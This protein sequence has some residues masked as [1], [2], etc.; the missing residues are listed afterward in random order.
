MY[1]GK[2]TLLENGMVQVDLMNGADIIYTHTVENDNTANA[3]IIPWVAQK[4]YTDS[5]ITSENH[6]IDWDNF[7]EVYLYND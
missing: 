5:T 6:V 2:K 1:K 7:D 3:Y 4:G